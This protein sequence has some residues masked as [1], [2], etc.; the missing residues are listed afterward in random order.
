[1]SVQALKFYKTVLKYDPDQKEIRKQYKKLKEV[2]PRPTL[3]A[4]LPLLLIPYES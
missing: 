4:P 2:T 3:P 1:M